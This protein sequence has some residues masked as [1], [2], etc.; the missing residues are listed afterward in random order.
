MSTA[1]P[2]LP[3]THRALVFTSTSQP[4]EVRSVPTP[5]PSPGSAIIRVTAT[6]ILTYAREIFTGVRIYPYPRPYVPG[7]AAVGHIV[8]LSRD[9]TTLKVGDLV[10]TE[11][12]VRARDD[13]NVRALQGIHQGGPDGVPSVRLVEDEDEWRHGSYAEYFKVPLENCHRLP[14]LAGGAPATPVQWLRMAQMLVPFGGLTSDG[15][16]DLRPGETVVI[17]PATGGFSGSAVELA[18]SMGARVVAVGRSLEGLRRIE[19]GLGEFVERGRLRTVQ[20]DEGV[21]PEDLAKAIGPVDC[22]LDLSPPA[23]ANSP[24]LKACILALRVRGRACLMGGIQGDVALPHGAIFRNDLQIT[25]KWMYER[26]SIGD[27]IKM[28]ETGV[29]YL[30]RGNSWSFKLEDWEAALLHAEKHA[31]WGQITVFEP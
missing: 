12:F 3:P 16:V 22:Y 5:A 29:L 4:L 11:T 6:S 21:T 27:L 2:A 9:A 14:E 20:M 31:R 1:V 23:A 13:P 8:A 7:S 24:H 17:A 26:E 30:G 28:A 15:G 18:L 25:G 10:L 19:E